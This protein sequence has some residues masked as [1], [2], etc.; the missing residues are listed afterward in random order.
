MGNP[1]RNGNKDAPINTNQITDLCDKSRKTMNKLDEIEKSLERLQ[2]AKNPHVDVRPGRPHYRVY[3]QSDILLPLR[4]KSSAYSIP[5]D[6]RESLID[7]PAV[8]AA[9]VTANSPINSHPLAFDEHQRV[10]RT[11]LSPRR[12]QTACHGHTNT[13]PVYYFN[14]DHSVADLMSVPINHP[15]RNDR[16]SRDTYRFA[17]RK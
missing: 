17:Q 2:K 4:E 9:Y 1:E 11:A 5:S 3:Q 7:W 8:N 10:P 14:I 6:S 16:P 13:N 12:S 15:P